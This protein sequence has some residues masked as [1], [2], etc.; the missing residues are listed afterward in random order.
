MQQWMQIVG[1]AKGLGG[2]GMPN[3]GMWKGP[4]NDCHLTLWDDW[5]GHTYLLLYS[6][7]TD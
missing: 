3:G 7:S 1:Q 5:D 6:Y 2:I 4:G